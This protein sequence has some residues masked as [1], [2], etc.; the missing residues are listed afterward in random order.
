MVIIDNDADEQMFIY[1]D[2]NRL[3]VESLS[4]FYPSDANKNYEVLVGY[5]VKPRKIFI[6]V[7]VKG[8]KLIIIDFSSSHLCNT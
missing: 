8:T 6:L 4:N 2:V 3:G 7:I 5:N 1:R